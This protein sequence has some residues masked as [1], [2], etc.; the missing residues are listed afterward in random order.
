MDVLK[1]G[2]Q[3]E[4]INATLNVPP[5]KELHGDYNRIKLYAEKLNIV[6]KSLNLGL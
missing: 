5:S 4:K 6:K 2:F 3:P 1:I